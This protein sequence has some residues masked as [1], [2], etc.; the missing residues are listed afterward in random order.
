MTSYEFWEELN[1]VFN[2]VVSY[3]EKSIEFNKK[4]ITPWIRLG[5]VFDKN[6]RQRESIAA[7]KQAVEM[8]PD[9]A[10]LW[11]ELGN[12]YLNE[13]EFEEALQA[14]RRSIELNPDMGW[15]YSNLGTVYMTR[16]NHEKAI[17][18][19]ERSITLLSEDKDKA[20]SWNRL[21]NLY[22]KTHQ[23]ALAL[24]AFQ[25]ADELDAGSYISNGEVDL[26]S[27]NQMVLPQPPFELKVDGEVKAQ[28]GSEAQVLIDDNQ[29]ET[30]QVPGNTSDVAPVSDLAV[31]APQVALELPKDNQINVEVS[32]DL[33]SA[34][35]EDEPQAGN[36]VEQVVLSSDDPQTTT[37]SID[38]LMVAGTATA[39]EVIYPDATTTQNEQVP[40]EDMEAASPTEMLLP[41]S[42][43]LIETET[44]PSEP[45]AL[46]EGK[47]I[48][49]EIANQ[50]QVD[51]MDVAEAATESSGWEISVDELIV[52]SDENPEKEDEQPVVNL[53]DEE[54]FSLINDT[55]PMAT[56]P[57]EVIASEPEVQSDVQEMI[58]EIIQIAEVNLEDVAAD[59]SSEDKGLDTGSENNIVEN[60]EPVMVEEPQLDDAEARE[61][62]FEEFLRDEEKSFP[63]INKEETTTS[64]AP[65]PVTIIDSFGD[66]QMEVDINNAKVWNELGNVYYNNGALEDAIVAYAKSIEL[67][68]NFAW[69]Y[70]NLALAYIQ[71][72][73]LAEA[74]LLYQR[75]IELFINDK[76]KAVAWN[77]LGNLYRRM[78]DYPN[79]IS[80]YQRAD[81]LDPNNVSS[82]IQSRFSLLGTLTQS[83][84][85]AVMQS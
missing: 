24:E 25:K 1:K 64:A 33:P 57:N 7:Y 8:D 56:D 85:A 61:L 84:E 12:L 49:T 30:T 48:E 60:D 27:L 22:R 41:K 23:Y 5:N 83:K 63:L 6:D 26:Q 16:G 4:F 20:I 46:P 78:D 51:Q 50:Q 73:R 28:F 34:E 75:S 43:E 55:D 14:F 68:R 13:S 44:A 18:C 58:A 59:F 32:P 10:Q 42:S 29:T 17:E 15:A 21:G 35:P 11:F 52:S 53:V 36:E 69:P 80:S 81:E 72:E 45:L 38:S 82:S 76:D 70:S 74:I 40:H 19:F 31:E 77:C 39:F 79:A 65:D 66:V 54:E 47:T 9:N 2:A 71:K 3:Q 62:A 37:T 67:D